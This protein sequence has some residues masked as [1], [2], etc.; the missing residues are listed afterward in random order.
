MRG[1]RTDAETVRPGR[2]GWWRAVL[3]TAATLALAVGLTA[4][5]AAREAGGPHPPQR[6]PPT[7]SRTR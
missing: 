4:P 7:R 3:A 1:N 6:L 2:R 5:A